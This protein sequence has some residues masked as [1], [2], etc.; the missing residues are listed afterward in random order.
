MIILPLEFSLP[1][2][3]VKCAGEKHGKVK[4]ALLHDCYYELTSFKTN[5]KILSCL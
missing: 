4:I 3:E 2:K 5:K 1:A